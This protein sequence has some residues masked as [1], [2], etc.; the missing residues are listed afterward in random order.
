[1]KRIPLDS[2]SIKEAGF[3]PR[4]RTLELMFTDGRVYRYF[5]VPLDVYA[6]LLD[7]PSVGRFFLE[8]IRDTYRFERL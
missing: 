6:N 3:D 4:A 7:A 2:S 5:D 1:M 8:N